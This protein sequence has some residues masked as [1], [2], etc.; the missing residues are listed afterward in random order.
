MKKFVD[1]LIFFGIILQ[2]RVLFMIKREQYLAKLRLF[3]NKEVIKVIT[4]IRRCGKSTLMQQFQDELLAQG[5][6]PQQIIAINFEDLQYDNL[7]DYKKLYDYLLSRVDTG[8]QNY[9]FLDEI[10]KVQDFQKVVDSLYVQKNIDI[11]ITGSNSDLLSSE[12]TSLLTGRYIEVKMLPLSFGEY[13]DNFNGADTRKLFNNYLQF[14]SMPYVVGLPNKE[15]I[16]IYLDGIFNTIVNVDIAS[17]Y[18]QVDLSILQSIA[19]YLFHNIG[20]LVS[21]TN[22]A[23]TLTSNNRKTT[24]NTV[25]KYIGYLKEC[26]LIYEASRY[27]VKGKQHLKSLSKYYVV[28]M[29]LR[30]LLLSNS[31]TDIGHTLE[32]VV[33]LELL[34]RGYKVYVGK[35]NDREVDFVAINSEGIEYYQVSASVMDADK[36]KTEL[37]PL[38]QI[39]DNHPKTLLTLDEYPLGNYDGIKIENAIDWLLKK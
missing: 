37:T 38:Q 22:I 35:L 6:L 25:E 27:D 17:R 3:K 10:Q 19:K 24:Y 15:A 39:K 30:N 2:R 13:V 31:A 12:L 16:D 1:F 21:S 18:S 23:N 4:G 14:G 34:R 26:F 32:N 29:G 36:L 11:Y 7:L 5:V 33:Y 20:S 8:A 28:D 9:I